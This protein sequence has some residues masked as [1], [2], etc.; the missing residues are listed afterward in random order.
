MKFEIAE[1]GYVFATVAAD[2]A[3]EAVQLALA[4]YRKMASEDLIRFVY[5]C[6]EGPVRTTWYV[7]D[8]RFDVE[9]VEEEEDE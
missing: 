7:G 1:N 2:S 5:N 4:S 3:A 9:L 8:E 6:E